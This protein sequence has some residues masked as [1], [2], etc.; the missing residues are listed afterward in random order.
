MRKLSLVTFGGHVQLQ[1]CRRD[2][3]QAKQEIEQGVQREKISDEKC[4]SIQRTVAEQAI[5]LSELRAAVDKAHAT[6]EQKLPALQSEV[7]AL[8]AFAKSKQDH[9]HLTIQDLENSAKAVSLD[10]ECQKK[11]LHEAQ[12]HETKLKEELDK[13][14]DEVMH[15]KVS[16]KS[17]GDE[18]AALREELTAKCKSQGAATSQLDLMVI[19]SNRMHVEA[20]ELKQEN[21]KLK[22]ELEKSR[23]E[24]TRLYCTI[25]SQDAENTT[26]GEE[27]SRLKNEIFQQKAATAETMADAKRL[28]EDLQAQ[29][30]QM[31][32]S[33]QQRQ[34]L[35]AHNKEQTKQI[36]NLKDSAGRLERRIRALETEKGGIFMEKGGLAEQLAKLDGDFHV[37][38]EQLSETSQALEASKRREIDLRAHA[39]ALQAKHETVVQEAAKNNSAGRMLLQ[40]CK[41]FVPERSGV[42]MILIGG[43]TSHHVPSRDFWV[44]ELVVGGSA[45]A[46]GQIELG[47]V[48][49]TVDGVKVQVRVDTRIQCLRSF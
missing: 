29:A 23:S 49:A 1:Q 21:E 5:S 7:Q 46:R 8:H 34:A 4:S 32:K 15:L 12:E 47:D 45:A 42:G 2:V 26:L 22:A 27:R 25:Q 13:S 44:K 16:N 43:L 37:L 33:E 24:A 18:I 48:L 31:A 6:I 40:A 39:E 10:V 17:Q 38:Q 14:V 9:F 36:A 41:G 35:D 20:A 3:V 19:K 30:I 28:R 11:L